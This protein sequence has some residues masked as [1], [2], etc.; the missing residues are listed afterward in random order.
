MAT[1]HQKIELNAQKRDII[2]S[3]INKL[4]NDGFIPAVLYGKNQE[5]I[6]L[7]VLVKDF[8]KAF[9]SAGESTLVYINVDDQAYPTIIHDVS[10]DPVRDTVLHADFYKVR[11]DEKIK[12]KVPV[13]FEGEAPAVKELLG[14]FVRNVN[15]L[16][17]E[18][19]PQDLPHEIN[20]DLSILKNFGDQIL[21]KNIKLDSNVRIIADAEDIVATV[22][23]PISEEQ[24]KA[25]LEAP[26]TAIED[27]E[28]IKKEKK[29]E[30]LPAEGEDV[31]PAEAPKE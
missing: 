12:T 14:I 31:A 5:S 19:L 10:R 3:G 23:E 7:Q 15:E 16:E 29:E 2:G 24:L 9:Q 8:N 21:V 20:I 25:D 1:K 6:P 30:E 27:V 26:T 18:A 22:Q 13:V 4:R 28:E 17:V 11:L